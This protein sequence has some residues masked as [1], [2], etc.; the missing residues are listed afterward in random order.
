MREY[1]KSAL[2][3][4]D[5][6]K[7]KRVAPELACIKIE[8]IL[9]QF[10]SRE[11]NVPEDFSLSLELLNVALKNANLPNERVIPRLFSL[12]CQVMIR[13][14]HPLAS[15]EVHRQIWKL[16]E[17]H[18]DYLTNNLEYNSHHVNDAWKQWIDHVVLGSNRSKRRINYNTKQEIDRLL[19]RME[20][21]FDDPSVPLVH[22]NN[23][24]NSF[25]FYYCNQQKP[26]EAYRL[27]R[28]VAE[29]SGNHPVRILPPVSS[30][31]ATIFA[32]S[33]AGKP[34]KALEIVQW[35]LSSYKKGV[36]PPPNSSSFNGLLDAWARSGRK[37]AGEKA[38][39]TMEWM[40]HLH[41]TEN[42]DTLPIEI[43]Y[44]I[45]INA[46][47]RSRVPH[48]PQ[49]AESILRRMVELYRNG[50]QVV[51]SASA[52]TSAMNTW[53][54]SKSDEAPARIALILDVMKEI[55]AKSNQIQVTVIPY[56]ILM[57]AWEQLARKKEGKQKL[58]CGNRALQAF[59]EMENS[60]I[61][62]TAEAHNSLITALHQTS[63]INA[64]FHFLELEEKYRD[65]SVQLDTRTFNSGLNALATLNKPD[66][67][68]KALNLLQRMFKYAR[69]DS[70]VQP[71]E[72][73][74][75]TILK[76]LSRSSGD[77]AAKNANDLLLEMH[78]M[79]SIDPSFISYN[80]CIIAWGRSND[81]KK[82]QHIEDLLRRFNTSHSISNM[83][84]K[85][86]LSVYNCVLSVCSHN[87]S[88]E[89]QSE[90]WAMTLT[91]MEELRNQT[92]IRPDQRT[93]LS[94]L[95][96]L[97]MVS[98]EDVAE[99]REALLHKEFSYCISDGLVSHEIL[100]LVHSISPKLFCHYFG[101]TVDPKNVSIPRGWS[102][103]C[104]ETKKSKMGIWEH[105]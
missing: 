5:Q 10:L 50:S 28:W 64:V 6:L 62:A 46:W 78:S 74:F 65:Q 96:V 59:A 40:E 48:A 95:R 103:K 18:Q 30:F 37:D 88:P 83:S 17:G 29:N 69:K 36:V 33:K 53:A 7:N 92:K 100:E 86:F 89:L 61:A 57:K 87:M 79:P 22:T 42:L 38:E 19:N 45:C 63:A 85:D 24:C 55:A 12:A 32:F 81:N 90:A 27:L 20:K 99:A 34:E 80:T 67:A 60:G 98:L 21:L 82:F 56:T 49:R 97:S 39:Q 23:S 52:F 3:F 77:D 66:V 15:K 2:Q 72:F 1:Q 76:V 41:Q 47:A 101:D 54:N 91:T 73:T 84:G 25:I 35:M 104:T 71:D 44:S 105:Q 102:R 8:E 11:N 51:P 14:G 93:Y 31:T 43:S 26:A 70:S 13:S 68:D 16:I 9:L 4:L 94:F 75:N 58:E